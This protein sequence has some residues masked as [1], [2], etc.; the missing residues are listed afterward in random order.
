MFIEY[1]FFII[2]IFVLWVLYVKKHTFFDNDFWDYI[3]IIF[4]FLTIGL[5]FFSFL[6]ILI[7]FITPF[8]FLKLKNYLWYDIFDFSAIIVNILYIP[9]FFIKDIYYF[10][11]L[12]FTLI[13]IILLRFVQ[14]GYSIGIFLFIFS[15][16]YIIGNKLWFLGN[17]YI[18]N[19]DVGV[20][21][22][23]ISLF[24]VLIRLLSKKNTQYKDIFQKKGAP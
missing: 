2:A 20:S 6:G 16:L 5:L 12:I 17:N 11:I 14:E 23:L 21:I 13:F 10:L 18:Y 4:I 15:I 7:I 22:L 24:A 1:V 3:V 9:Y 8:I 19:L